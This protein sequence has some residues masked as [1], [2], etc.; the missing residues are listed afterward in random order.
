MESSERAFGRSQ[1]QTNV[2]IDK[3]MVNCY[4]VGGLFFLFAPSKPLS[5]RPATKGGRRR[6]KSTEETE[7][8]R[9][10]K[11]DKRGA[12]ADRKL[13]NNFYFVRR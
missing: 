11:T 13:Y 7:E 2:L 1:A 9:G 12:L 3:P 8:R 5:R 4:S 10:R 6:M